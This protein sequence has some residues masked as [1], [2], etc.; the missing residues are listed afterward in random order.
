MVNK[1]YTVENVINIWDNA[2]GDRITIREDS[3]GLSLI[4][5]QYVDTENKIQ[6]RITMTKQLADIFLKQFSKY[7]ESYQ[8]KNHI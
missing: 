3:D 1:D 5:V 2:G 6:S 7:L 4:E 8:E